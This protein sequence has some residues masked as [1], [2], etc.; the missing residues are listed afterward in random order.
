MEIEQC[1][2]ERSSLLTLNAEEAEKFRRK[3]LSRKLG[4]GIGRRCRGLE[5]IA[6]IL[7]SLAEYSSVVI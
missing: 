6:V 2:A 7:G 3:E 5:Q 4:D 1:K